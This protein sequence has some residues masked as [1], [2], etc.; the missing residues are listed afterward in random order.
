MKV[1][2]QGTGFRV[3]WNHILAFLIPN[4]GLQQGSVISQISIS[5]LVENE[6]NTY[7]TLMM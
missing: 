7:F 6:D 2:I 3:K 1:G 4:V 5:L